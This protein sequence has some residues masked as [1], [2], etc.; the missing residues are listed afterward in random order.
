MPSVSPS[1]LQQTDMLAFGRPFMSF[2]VRVISLEKRNRDVCL[3]SPHSAG[4]RDAASVL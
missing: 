2:R 4:I 3:L 1:G